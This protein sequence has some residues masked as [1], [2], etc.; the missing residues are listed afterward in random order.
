LS[1]ILENIT[2][3]ALNSKAKLR[4][5][6]A[7][8][9]Y[10]TVKTNDV[11]PL[12]IGYLAA[13]LDNEL[14]SQV[15]IKIFKYPMELEAAIKQA[16]PD[17]LGLSHY[18]WNALLDRLF[19]KM[20]KQVNPD[21]VTVMGGPN[22][23]LEPEEI[24]K[25]LRNLP[26]L[27][28]YITFEGE[29]PF[30]SLIQARLADE[31]LSEIMG[32][33]SIAKDMFTYHFIDPMKKKRTINGTSPYLSG[34]LDPFLKNPDLIPVLES[35]RGCPFSCT[36]CCWGVSALSLVR[37]RPLEIIFQEIDYI[38]EHSAGQ[39]TW[40]LADANFGILPRDLDIARKIREVMD[41]KGLPINV[42]LWNSKN[43]SKR[44]TE[45][46]ETIG[47]NSFGLIAIQSSDLL[48][49]KHAGRG[50]IKTGET[51]ASIDYYHE[52]WIP[53]ATDLLIGRLPKET[54]QSHL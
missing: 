41:K 39:V 33:A 17:V 44:N 26:D 24:E 4:I 15:D 21:A 13:L 25:F 10:D 29:Q 32:C 49:L 18:S 48:V 2:Q 47:G 8:L 53:V 20:V 16:P 38:A 1:K 46:S 5:F 50:K 43:T 54:Y 23:R 19:L 51:K 42:T 37:Q 27:D 12:N 11:V 22:T 30:L 45:I 14:G 34:W 36:Y 6:L 35:N 31:P 40:I 52:K 9:V 28:H 3:G 7:D